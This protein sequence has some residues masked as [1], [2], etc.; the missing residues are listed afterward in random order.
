MADAIFLGL[1]GLTLLAVGVALGAV[2]VTRAEAVDSRLRITWQAML[3]ANRMH[4]AF[5]IAREQMRR[6]AFE[7]IRDEVTER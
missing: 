4:A 1:A 3:I 5:L 2:L 6:D 7:R